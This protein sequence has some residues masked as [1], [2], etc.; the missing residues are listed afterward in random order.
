MSRQ[1]YIRQAVA[2]SKLDRLVEAR[3]AAEA[4]KR[5]DPASK[6]AANLYQ[7]VITKLRAADREAVITTIPQWL[8]IFARIGGTAAC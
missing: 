5:L 4:A 2:L 1:G 3:N 7:E 8:D 6:P